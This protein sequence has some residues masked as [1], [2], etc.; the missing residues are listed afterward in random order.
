MRTIRGFIWGLLLA[1]SSLM[2][3]LTMWWIYCK[4]KSSEKKD[5]PYGRY[6]NYHQNKK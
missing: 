2:V 6:S 5:S 1:T 3:T 4:S